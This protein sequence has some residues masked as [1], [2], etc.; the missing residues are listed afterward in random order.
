MKLL[1]LAHE[2]TSDE[3][4]LK[5]A[6]ALVIHSYDDQGVLIEF[7][8]AMRIENIFLERL[9]N[10]GLSDPYVNILENID[11][12]NLALKA[13]QCELIL[14]SEFIYDKIIDGSLH[15]AD[16]VIHEEVEFKSSV[17]KP[18]HVRDHNHFLSET[19]RWYIYIRESDN[20]DEEI[21][22]DAMEPEQRPFG[23]DMSKIL[24]P[25]FYMLIH[26]MSQVELKRSLLK[27]GLPFPEEEW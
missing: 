5:D 1:M 6:L 26:R 21:V 20:I 3:E 9:E 22:L 4:Y 12:R 14:Y 19:I 17:F 27:Q 16:L 7:L 24:L 2:I 8:V 23:A 25:N 10:T 11:L 13:I 15:V 18:F